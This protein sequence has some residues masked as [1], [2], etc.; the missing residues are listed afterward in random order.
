MTVDQ[1]RRLFLA[2]VG[3]ALVPVALAYGVAPKVTM[4]Y[5]FDVEATGAGTLNVFRA[6]MGLYLALAGFWLVG[7]YRA[8]LRT[9]ALWS[10]ILFMSGVGAGR[11]LSILLDGWP[12]PLLV[13]FT[14]VEFVSA[15]TGF[16]LLR[17]GGRHTATA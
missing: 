11:V 13:F 12:H 1:M 2:L 5:L 7:A 17:A 9:G 4:P 14:G 3:V 6:I 8:D 15:L 10:L 16:L